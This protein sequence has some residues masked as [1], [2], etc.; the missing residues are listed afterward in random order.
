M[1]PGVGGLPYFG[2]I[3]GMILS[4]C[5]IL[6]TQPAYNRKLAANNNVTI[7]EWRL[8]P[9]IIGGASFA[10]GL[11][12]FGWTG[13]KKDIP[14]IVPTLSGLATGFG[15]MAIFL[16]LLNYL[17]D[18]YLMFAASAIAANTFLRSLC[19]AVFPLFAT[20]MFN[21]MGIQWALTFLG[22]LATVMIPI[23]VIFYVYG[24]RIRGR[25]AYAPTTPFVPNNDDE[26]ETPEAN[27]GEKTTAADG[28]HSV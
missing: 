28:D 27:G 7:P 20:Y 19:G 9:V 6:L 21:G 22:A 11:F 4:G 26:A 1:S 16:Q 5:Y 23:P 8:P 12:W 24:K 15:I 13:Y 14:W 2:M 25:S 18:A 17:V 3:V 10:I